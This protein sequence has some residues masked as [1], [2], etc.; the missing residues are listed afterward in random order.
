MFGYTGPAS[1]RVFMGPRSP[2]KWVS[3]K[4]SRVTSSGEFI[5]EVDGFRFIAISAVVCHHLM[6]AYLVDTGRFGVA[7]LPADWPRA[8]DQ[9]L[10][11]GLAFLGY[12]GVQLFFVISGFVLV[13]PFARSHL[14]VGAAPSLRSYYLR[15]LT[16]IEPPYVI[17]LLISFLY[18]SARNE[19][20]RRL[21]PHLVAS[22]LYSH[23]LV[24]G[25][26]SRINGLAWSLEIE[27]QFYLIAPLLAMVFAIRNAAVRRAVL[28][29][30]VVVGGVVPQ[31]CIAQLGQPRL[32]LTV[33]NCLQ[34]FLAGFLLAELHLAPSARGRA[35][36]HGWDAVVAASGTAMLLGVIREAHV[37]LPFVIVLFYLGMFRG[38]LA[39]QI[40]R[41]R[42]IVIV[43]GMCYTIYLYHVLVIG[44]LT[45]RLA[46]FSVPSRP[47][48]LEFLVYSGV[49]GAAILV[50]CAC[51]F[52]YTEKPFMKAWRGV[53]VG[54]RGPASVSPTGI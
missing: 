48:W 32:Y 19:G 41:F 10:V 11:A 6:S 52:V 1:A 20:W 51:L 22:L 13:L 37:V 31:W 50:V 15:R 44:R 39:N 29:G 4:L 45:R 36:T 28:I 2:G 9:S 40:I 24:Y 49:H 33:L 27:V 12:F 54:R 35:P 53:H 21:V 16:R 25:E 8:L 34:Y 42:P 26:A 5:P 46:R 47:L 14:A 38:A 18:I 7:S 43:G 3:E 17:N 30:A 23:S